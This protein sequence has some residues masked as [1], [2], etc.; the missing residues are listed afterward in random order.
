MLERGADE[1]AEQPEC[2]RVAVAEGVG[3]ARKHLDHAQG[4]LIVPE[5]HG[6]QRA[7]ALR[8]VGVVSDA[9]IGGHVV[10]ALQVAGADGQPRQAVAQ[11]EPRALDADRHLGDQLVALDQLDHHAGGAGERPAPLG[12]DPHD[13][14]R[15]EPGGGHRLLHLDHRLEQLGVEPHLGLG[16]LAL[17]DVEPGAEVAHLPPGLVAD[18][19]PGA[20]APPLL[21][22]A[23]DQPVL[24]VAEGAALGQPG[25][26]GEQRRTVVGVDVLE[27]FLV[28]KV[29]APRT[30]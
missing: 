30:R 21:P 4:A 6:E 22:G 5:R 28:A 9:W 15:I 12:D 29:L 7:N 11:P 13:R 19:L 20:G 14:G 1:A 25:P 10:G 27:E 17:G 16:E 18:R 8:A 26:F 2:L 24:L 23:G 3:V